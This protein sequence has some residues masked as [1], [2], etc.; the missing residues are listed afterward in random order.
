MSF[1][2]IDVFRAKVRGIA[3]AEHVQLSEVGSVAVCYWASFLASILAE[4]S[5]WEDDFVDWKSGNA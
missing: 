4:L 1:V 3:F 5:N 2:A